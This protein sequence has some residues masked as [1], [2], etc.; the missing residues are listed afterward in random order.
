MIDFDNAVSIGLDPS[1]SKKYI[2]YAAIDNGRNLI[3]IGK[4]PLEELSVALRGKLS[5]VVVVGGPRRPNAG[6]M[7]NEEI[8][9][10]QNPIPKPGKW[11][12]L[13][14][15][16]YQ[17]LQMGYPI[18]KT[19]SVDG[20]IKGWMENSFELYKALDFGGFIPFVEGKGANGCFVEASPEACYF[21]WA[22]NKLLPKRTL[23]G[24]MQRQ[25][26]IYDL[27]MRISDPLDALEE[28]TRSKI[29]QGKIPNGILFNGPEL[30]A[31]ALATMGWNLSFYPKRIQFT[32]TDL[33]GKVALL[34]P[35][36][37]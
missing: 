5:T 9:A 37:L 14:L 29:R 12:A 6:L 21:Q 10:A 11:E 26:I 25:L 15:V 34:S 20:K 35:E 24:R 13:R 8:R 30:Q 18:Y 7:T 19:A 33:E 2:S 27:R 31:L 4:S 1:A 17:M 16:E 3:A 36:E 28:F 23:I 32:G 22:S